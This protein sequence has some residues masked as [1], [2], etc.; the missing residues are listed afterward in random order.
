MFIRTYMICCVVLSALLAG[1]ATTPTVDSGAVVVESEDFRAAIVFNDSDRRKIKRYYKN[2]YR[3]KK[4]PPGL[5]KKHKSHPGLRR[6]IEKNREL[7]PDIQGRRLP[8][9]LE[10]KL[11]HL[12][13]DYVRLSVG[14]DIL[15]MHGRTRYVLD[16]LFD[17]D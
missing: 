6:H 14:G 11:S 10:R 8:L 13:P 12:P 9:D 1:C 5:A 2:K 16:V 17:V 3:R 15:L 4:L 7:P